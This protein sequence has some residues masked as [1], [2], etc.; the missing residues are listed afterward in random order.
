MAAVRREGDKWC[1]EGED[2]EDSGAYSQN[3]LTALGGRVETY[4]YL[5]SEHKNRKIYSVYSDI[6][7]FSLDLFPDRMA[8][9][10]NM[11]KLRI[12]NGYDVAGVIYLVN[13]WGYTGTIGVP[14]QPMR[15]FV[16]NRL[17]FQRRGDMV[18]QIGSTA[19]EDNAIAK[20]DEFQKHPKSPHDD[21]SPTPKLITGKLKRKQ[22][23]SSSQKKKKM[24][25]KDGEEVEIHSSDD[26]FAE[27]H[28]AESHG[29]AAVIG[30][31]V[32][33]DEDVDES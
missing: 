18:W 21:G 3:L 33:Y 9:L 4:S 1:F 30:G 6:V 22:E 23:P 24:K 10:R 19:D 14:N 25:I 27:V 8:H 28:A 29:S 11:P 31:G 20:R 16:R 15:N 2:F 17:D 32:H 5:D 7:G 26:D 13:K 12:R